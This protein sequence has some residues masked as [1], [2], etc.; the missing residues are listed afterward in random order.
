MEHKEMSPSQKVKLEKIK[1]SI[2]TVPITPIIMTWLEFKLVREPKLLCAWWFPYRERNCIWGE[3]GL[4][5]WHD[6][7]GK[8]K[9][10][11]IRNN[12][13]VQNSGAISDTTKPNLIL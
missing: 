11:A 12:G 9:V 13:M 1:N 10:Q 7:V 5:G 4:V 3:E 6:Q 8:G 2:F